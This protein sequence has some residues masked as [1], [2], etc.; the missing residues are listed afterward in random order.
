MIQQWFFNIGIY[1]RL[2]AVQLRGQMQYRA[3]FWLELISTIILTTAEFGALA[4]A[5][6]SEHSLGGWHVFEVALLFGLVDMGFGLMD[7]VFSG[8]DPHRFGPQVRLGR[9]DQLL[10]RPVNITTQVLG[11]DFPLRRLGR[12]GSGML[13]TL[14]AFSQLDIAWSWDKLLLLPMILL[15]TVSFFG[16]LFVLGAVFTFWTVDG[17]EALNV[18]TYGSKY[19]A[20]HPMNIYPNWIRRFFTYVIPAAFLTY[21][22]ALYLLDKPDPNGLPGWVAWLVLPLGSLTLLLSSRLWQWGIRHY[23]STGS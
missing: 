17:L 9:F 2:L 20:Y 10:L 21:Y 15:G 14:L 12:I 8:F 18:T 16:G 11:S 22:P 5:L 19:V 3:S 13:V 6:G 1:R 23:Q 4:L 7:M